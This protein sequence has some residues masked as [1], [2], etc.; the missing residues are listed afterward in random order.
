MSFIRTTQP[1]NPM[2]AYL[3]MDMM[4]E[5]GGKLRME[6]V[7]AMFRSATEGFINVGDIGEALAAL[8]LLFSFD[9]VHAI[10]LKGLS[11]PVK[12]QCIP[13]AK[14]LTHPCHP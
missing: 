12:V 10:S 5:S 9:R 1:S 13:L 8:V 7:K 11:P 14:F 6:L 2:L 3:S 4:R